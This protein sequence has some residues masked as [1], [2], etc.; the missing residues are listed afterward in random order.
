M[1]IDGEMAVF[2]LSIVTK[3]SDVFKLRYGT[4]GILPVTRLEKHSDTK[5]IVVDKQGR[6]TC[7]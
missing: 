6:N 4:Y 5:F 2:W 7:R 3:K 1:G